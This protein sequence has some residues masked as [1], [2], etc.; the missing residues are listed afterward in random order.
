MRYGWPVTAAIESKHRRPRAARYPFMASVVVFDLDSG[1][2]TAERTSD[3]SLFGCLVAPGGAKPAD[4]KPIGARVRLQIT[5]M[6][7]V[8]EAA[9]RVIHTRAA[10]GVGIAFTKVEDRY[11]AVLERW[12]AE[13]RSRKFKTYHPTLSNQRN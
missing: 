7:E 4:A 11:V 8:F 13:L 1:R 6:R 3:L 12:L 10:K 2:T 5:Y 9:G